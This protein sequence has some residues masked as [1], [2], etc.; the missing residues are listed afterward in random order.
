MPALLT[1][2]IFALESRTTSV[3]GFENAYALGNQGPD[4]F[5]PYGMVPWKKHD[6]T[7]EIRP[8][9]AKLHHTKMVDCYGKM[10]G[11]AL[12]SPHQEL[13][14]SYLR[15][16]FAH[17]ALDRLA[18]A[19]IFY[20]SG[21]D[22]KGEL[23]GFYKWSHGYFEACLD[24]ALAKR[25]KMKKRPFK[26]LK[27]DK[28]EV[29]IISKMWQDCC[30]YPLKEDSFFL[31]WKDSISSMKLIQSRTGWKRP[32]LKKI[33]GV[34]S[35]AYAQSMP[36]RIGKYEGLDFEN[37]SHS[38]WKDPATGEIR[39]S[40]IDD[41]FAEAKLDLLELEK[42]LE[43]AKQGKEFLTRLDAWEANL[44]H[45]GTPYGGSKRYYDLCWPKK[46]H[47]ID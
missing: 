11:Y 47:E 22:E 45:D 15:G 36:G 3:S 21:F 46:E 42:I 12:A 27:C 17:F 7:E 1:H 20:R 25:K 34:T 23:H 18:H 44:D 5:M 24:K 38:E 33:M 26:V 19:Y 2:Y 30:P 16:A 9:G 8:V 35:Q 13:L 37:L 6:D 28:Q 14:L 32:I 43:A 29:E 10:I 31:S 41:L 4:V 39:T 40:S